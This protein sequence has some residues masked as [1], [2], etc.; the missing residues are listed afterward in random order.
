MP[1][2]YE[3]CGL[4]QIY[5]LRYGTVPVV[6]AT[7]GLDD[8]I[9]ENTGFKFADYDCDGAASRPGTAVHTFRT[10]KT[11]WSTLMKNGMTRDHSWAA[12]ARQYRKL[13]RQVL[14]A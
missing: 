5:S 1:S 3:P 10:D 6:R 9:D 14:A 8:T 2:H 11:R 12:S 7:G 13:Y 4:N